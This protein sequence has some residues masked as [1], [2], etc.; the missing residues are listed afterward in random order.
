MIGY[1]YSSWDEGVFC[2]DGDPNLDESWSFVKFPAVNAFY[3]DCGGGKTD[4][5]LLGFKNC[6]I[7][8][9]DEGTT[10]G[11][12]ID[13][14]AIGGSNAFSDVAIRV[15]DETA[16]VACEDGV[17]GYA[18]DDGGCR[19]IGSYAPT[20]DAWK[21]RWELAVDDAGSVWV[22]CRA[23]LVRYNDRFSREFPFPAEFSRNSTRLIADRDQVAWARAYRYPALPSDVQLALYWQ[24]CELQVQTDRT[25]Y[26]PGD[27][28]EMIWSMKNLGTTIAGS[29]YVGVITPSGEVLCFG[30]DGWRTGLVPVLREAT[31]IPGLMF[32]PIAFAAESVTEST[33]PGEYKL[34]TAIL[35]TSG[36]IE[37]YDDF[38]FTIVNE[39]CHA[40]AQKCD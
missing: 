38:S 19:M 36:T 20:D 22:L 37:A 21:P 11:T 26:G 30:F 18:C 7:G 14:A 39:Q 32:K 2:V 25:E 4:R 8:W 27:E 13:L 33:P 29:L 34:A 28:V 1:F 10:S 17:Y 35:S 24:D 12:I 23:G 31:Y 40:E 3:L 16:W 9:V 6:G 15:S 5:C